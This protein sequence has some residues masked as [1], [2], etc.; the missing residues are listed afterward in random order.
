V[1]E[2]LPLLVHQRI[3]AVLTIAERHAPASQIG[4]LSNTDDGHIVRLDARA[5]SPQPLFDCAARGVGYREAALVS[6]LGCA[7]SGQDPTFSFPACGRSSELP[8]RSA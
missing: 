5:S 2:C 1:G 3:T 4:G 6:L 7:S 8:K